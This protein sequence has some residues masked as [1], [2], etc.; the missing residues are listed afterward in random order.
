MNQKIRDLLQEMVNESYENLVSCAKELMAELIPIF[1]EALGEGKGSQCIVHI[2]ATCLAVDGKLTAKEYQFVKDIYRNQVTDQDIEDLASSHYSYD[3]MEEVNKIVDACDHHTKAS[4]LT[5]C[6]CFL[7][8]DETISR[9]E[10]A[11]L[12]ILLD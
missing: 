8:V 9:E 10:V 12:N 11:F 3:I 2:F 1:D 4:L 7:A 6:T 5:L